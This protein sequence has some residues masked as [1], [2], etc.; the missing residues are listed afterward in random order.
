MTTSHTPA[1][2]ALLDALERT[3]LTRLGSVVEAEVQGQDGDTY[4]VRIDGSAWACSCPRAVYAGRNGRPCKHVGAL[5]L[6]RSTLPLTLG[7]A[8]ETAHHP[9]RRTP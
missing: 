5:R 4:R 1:D 7:G 2:L 8:A 6:I 9:Q 3:R